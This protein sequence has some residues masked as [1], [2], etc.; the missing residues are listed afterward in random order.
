MVR[1]PKRSN[2]LQA[3]INKLQDATAALSRADRHGHSEAEIIN[4]CLELVSVLTPE[5]VINLERRVIG[6]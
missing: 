6:L 4:K 1:K 5:E 3:N 2:D